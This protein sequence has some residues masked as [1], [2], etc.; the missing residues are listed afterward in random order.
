[1][2]RAPQIVESSV[3]REEMVVQDEEKCVERHIL[4]LSVSVSVRIPS[5]VPR[6]MLSP[7]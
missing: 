6:V 4:I 2:Q 5:L 1:M 7:T 3:I